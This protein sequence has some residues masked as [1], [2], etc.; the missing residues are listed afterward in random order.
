[1]V[2]CVSEIRRITM[3]YAFMYYTTRRSSFGGKDA[4][5]SY[6]SNASMNKTASVFPR[7]TAARARA[8]AGLLAPDT[9]IFFIVQLGHVPRTY[10][11][12]ISSRRCHF[13][14]VAEFYNSGNDEARVTRVTH[15]VPDI[16]TTKIGLH[17]SQTGN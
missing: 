7:R 11:L 13:F 8:R 9:P 5:R 3:L 2:L 6:H 16:H 12:Q 15:F 17:V 1:M 10:S 4:R 14:R